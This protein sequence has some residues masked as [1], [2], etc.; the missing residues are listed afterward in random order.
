MFSVVG[1]ILCK[2]INWKLIFL[3]LHSVIFCAA[4]FYRQ[5]NPRS[6]CL[7]SIKCGLYARKLHFWTEE[8]IYTSKML[9]LK[10]SFIVHATATCLWISHVFERIFSAFEEFKWWHWSSYLQLSW[11][12]LFWW[13]CLR[14]AEMFRCFQNS[15]DGNHQGFSECVQV[16]LPEEET[17]ENLPGYRAPSVSRK[18]SWSPHWAPC[19][20]SFPL[21][22]FSPFIFH[23]NGI[24]NLLFHRLQS[25]HSYTLKK[26]NYL[27]LS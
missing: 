3:A 2:S 7:E 22:V 27:K 17:T 20:L 5:N 1:W 18:T 19:L 15:W 21:Y 24:F 23:Y 26:K 6:L 12:T 11:I 9:V 14:V 16:E 4:S 13:L 8:F 10:Y 25:I